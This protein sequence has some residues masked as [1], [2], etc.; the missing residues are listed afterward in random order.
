MSHAN[1]RLTMHGRVLLV[2]RVRFEHR[3]VAEG[4]RLVERRRIEQAADLLAAATSPLVVGGGGV[5]L[6]D[7][8]GEF[9]AV[10]ERLQAA[11]VNTREGKGCIDERNPLFVGTAWVNRRL[12]PVIN[13]ADVILAVGTRY[14]G[15]GLEP[16]QR[17]IHIDVDERDRKSVV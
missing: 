13:Q 1:A 10:A 9:T 14:Q 11:V 5:V 17:L 7:A 8:S 4:E 16:G 3:P 15:V 12:K 2:R 6:A